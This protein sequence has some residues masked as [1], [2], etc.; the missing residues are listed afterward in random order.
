[1]G[2]IVGK[3]KHRLAESVFEIGALCET[4]DLA[5]VNF[6]RRIQ[7]EDSFS[8]EKCGQNAPGNGR[9]ESYTAITKCKCPGITLPNYIFRYRSL[10]APLEGPKLSVDFQ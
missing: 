10:I 1:M 4:G 7:F 6:R 2:R 8:G 9:G 5:P 3:E